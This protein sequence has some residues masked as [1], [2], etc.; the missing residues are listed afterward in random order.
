[1]FGR[2]VPDYVP[3]ARRASVALLSFARLADGV[4]RAARRRLRRACVPPVRHR[5]RVRDARD[6]RDERGDRGRIRGALRTGAAR[7]WDGNDHVGRA[8]A[9]RQRR[10]RQPAPDGRLAAIGRIARLRR[11]G[12]LHPE[13]QR[14]V[15]ERRRRVRR[16]SSGSVPSWPTP[17]SVGAGRRPH[18]ATSSLDVRRPPPLRT[19]IGI[20]PKLLHVAFLDR[21]N[22]D[23]S[24]GPDS[25]R[26]LPDRWA[27]EGRELF[28]AY[29]GGSARSKMTIE[30]FERPWDVTA[31]ARNLNTVVKLAEMAAAM[32]RPRHRSRLARTCR[33]EAERT[34]CGLTRTASL[35]SAPGARG[36]SHDR[37]D[38]EHDRAGR[39]ARAMGARA[40]G[41]AADQAVRPRSSA[42]SGAA[43]LVS[44]SAEAFVIA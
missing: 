7:R 25:D 11:R 2:A 44:V 42:A 24:D 20:D 33:R 30:Q 19:D 15:P 21:L 13:R 9:G 36:Q 12:D 37:T 31:T 29:P 6:G 18:A 43:R 8:P 40:E 34:R 23:L 5:P 32:S 1:M 22:T 17:R 35:T 26:W 39:R 27:I 16:S 3:S 10:R 14:R 38:H 41:D 4:Q 28:L